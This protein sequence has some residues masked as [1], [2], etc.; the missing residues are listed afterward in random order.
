MA[1]FARR[2]ELS[3]RGVKH[4]NHVYGFKGF[5]GMR[6]SQSSYE[7]HVVVVDRLR[8]HLDLPE[9]IPNRACKITASDAAWG[10]A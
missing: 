6:T 10:A 8:Q 2:V 5:S 9:L 7:R 4:L 3:Q 1:F